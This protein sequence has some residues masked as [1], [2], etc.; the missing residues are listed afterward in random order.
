[1]TDKPD[2]KGIV[3]NPLDKIWLCRNCFWKGR[4]GECDIDFLCPECKSDN[5]YNVNEPTII[6]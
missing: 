1:M 3:Q 4:V 5:I 6:N 2:I